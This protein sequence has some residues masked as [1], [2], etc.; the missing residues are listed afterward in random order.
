[1]T[2]EEL[3]KLIERARLMAEEYETKYNEFTKI[4]YKKPDILSEYILEL[5]VT[6][7][8]SKID[9]LRKEGEESFK[10]LKECL[11]YSINLK[12]DKETIE[13]IKSSRNNVELSLK[14]LNKAY[15][16]FNKIHNMMAMATKLN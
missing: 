8:L 12:I 11:Y 15:K 2:I 6:D 9:N 16:D 7:I 3:E 14:D 5:L 10:L 4:I 1:M 13:I